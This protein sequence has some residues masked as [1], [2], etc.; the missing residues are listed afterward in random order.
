MDGSIGKYKMILTPLNC[1]HLDDCVNRIINM[2]PN[3]T[4]RVTHLRVKP[5]M[6]VLTAY[7][8]TR[9]IIDSRFGIHEFD[10]SVDSVSIS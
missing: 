7:K 4:K 6:M 5:V 10:A 9:P 3:N 1:M 2:N 8:S